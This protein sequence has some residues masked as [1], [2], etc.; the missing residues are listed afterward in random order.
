MATV[1]D[2]GN[3]KSLAGV[4][5]SKWQLQQILSSS[6][7]PLAL[8]FGYKFFINSQGS[9]CQDAP[10]AWLKPFECET[11]PGIGQGE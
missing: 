11:A 2:D 5:Q 3:D 4:E 9:G 1:C 10:P 8:L 7:F 6:N